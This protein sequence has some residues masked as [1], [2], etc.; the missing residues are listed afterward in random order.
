MDAG[1]EISRFAKQRCKPLRAWQV[2]FDKLDLG[3]VE[4]ELYCTFKLLESLGYTPL[5]L[6]LLLANMVKGF[7]RLWQI[8][9][10][11]LPLQT[12]LVDARLTGPA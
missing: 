9:H 3:V 5:N 7:R 11:F 2:I 4:S 6:E 1:V 10:R 8:S 12:E